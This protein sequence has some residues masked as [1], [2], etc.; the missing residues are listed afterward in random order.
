[1]TDNLKKT[2]K[3]LIID[4]EP[5]LPLAVY[6]NFIRKK[7]GNKYDLDDPVVHNVPE[8]P[9]RKNLADIDFIL[10]DMHFNDPDD[11]NKEYKW[12]GVDFLNRLSD[13]N[14]KR[15][16]QTKIPI[17]VIVYSYFDEIDRLTQN[18]PNFQTD[19]VLYLI[20]KAPAPGPKEN[21]DRLSML[22][23]IERT[24]KWIDRERESLAFKEDNKDLSARTKE[25]DRILKKNIGLDSKQY[26]RVE[27]RFTPGE[28]D[29]VGKSKAMAN[30]NQKMNKF[31][32]TDMTILIEGDTGTGK[33]LV[34][35]R[36]HQLSQ[37]SNKLFV[38]F[39]CASLVSSLAS[40]E[41]YGHVKG[42]YTGATGVRKGFFK[43]ADKGTIFL[44]EISEMPLDQQPKLLRVIQEGRFCPLGKEEEIEVDVRIIAATNRDL[45]EAV[46]KGTFR[47]DL[48]YRLNVLTL[49]VPPLRD[50]EGDIM[51]LSNHFLK[52]YMAI[53]KKQNTAL[54]SE[55]AR[56]A[57]LSYDWQGNVRELESAIM[58]VAVSAEKNIDVRHLP[59]HIIEPETGFRSEDKLGWNNKRVADIVNKLLRDYDKANNAFVKKYDQKSFEYL[60]TLYI[61]DQWNDLWKKYKLLRNVMIEGSRDYT[62]EQKVA[63]AEEMKKA[64]INRGETVKNR[65]AVAMAMGMTEGS[66]KGMVCQLRRKNK[67]SSA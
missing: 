12:N 25:Q 35:R 9:S 65:W 54:I 29:I 51:L 34:A 27:K 67:D 63:I 30:L 37:R 59:K 42:A 55:K 44:D 39:N 6:N 48:Y 43:W 10:L 62:T 41:L 19:E 32:P 36:T 17:P 18:Y 14:K 15:R 57:L 61:G 46:K 20:P 60:K 38:P 5:D 33:E 49:H 16:Q 66:L 1:M 50:R 3:A 47:E 4:D 7:L 26:G 21:R 52:K 56:E 22:F 13:F 11:P 40:S 64:L 45:R 2:Y 53:L 31:A 8:E 23:A 58:Y 28:V 24:C